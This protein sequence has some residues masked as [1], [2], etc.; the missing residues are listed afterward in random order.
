MT[1]E[2]ALKVAREWLVPRLGGDTLF[3]EA[4]LAALIER[5]RAT[6]VEAA[7]PGIERR[8]RVKALHWADGAS[9]LQIEAELARLAKEE[10]DATK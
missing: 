8:A 7:M 9:S 4:T 3:H 2:Q 1:D 5:Q 10:Q 6:A